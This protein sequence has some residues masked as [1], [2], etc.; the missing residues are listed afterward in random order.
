MSQNRPV[1]FV[2]W[3]ASHTIFRFQNLIIFDKVDLGTMIELMSVSTFELCKLFLMQF[4]LINSENGRCLTLGSNKYG[5]LGCQ[6]AN[7]IPDRIAC[8]PALPPDTVIV[9]LACGDMF[10]VALANGKLALSTAF[11][12]CI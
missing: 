12:A 2:S 4:S 10:T 6:T 5:Q 11:R 1:Q 9:D 8:V 7:K 3:C